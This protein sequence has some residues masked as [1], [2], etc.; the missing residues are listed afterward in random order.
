[1][2]L[3]ER[4]VRA[5]IDVYKGAG[6]EPN[7]GSLLY[8]TLRQAG[9]EPSMRGSCRVEG[10]PTARVYDYLASTVQSLWPSMV[11]QGLPLDGIDID[12]LSEMLRSE[13]EKADYSVAY[14]R[15]TGAWARA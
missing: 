2:P 15:L 3:F 10:G 13:A 12:T 11:E 9:F 4:C 14:P 5:V 6:S 7:M 1:M 8:T